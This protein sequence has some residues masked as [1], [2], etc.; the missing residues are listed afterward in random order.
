MS[1]VV[2]IKDAN[3][4]TWTVKLDKRVIGRITFTNERGEEPYYQY[5]PKGSKLRGEK[6]EGIDA[7]NRCIRSLGDEE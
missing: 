3:K 6:F 4:P 1:N 5:A 2:V 7:L